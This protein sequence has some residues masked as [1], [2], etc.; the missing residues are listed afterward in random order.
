M[1]LSI[2]RNNIKKYMQN[3]N[4]S[5][6]PSFSNGFTSSMNIFPEPICTDNSKSAYEVNYSALYS[7]WEVIANDLE[8]SINHY[9]TKQTAR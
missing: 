4:I 9:A 3:V 7:D 1:N 6:M 5:N 2:V 8:D